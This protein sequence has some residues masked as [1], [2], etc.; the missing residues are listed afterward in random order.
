MNATPLAIVIPFDKHV[1]FH[2]IVAIALLFYTIAHTCGHYFSIRNLEKSPTSYGVSAIQIAWLS[3]PGL[4]GHL[5]VLVF[6]LILSSSLESVKKT[7]FEL[8]WYLHHLFTVF[9]ALNSIHGIFCFVIA[10]DGSCVSP[11]F[12]KCAIGP[13]ALYMAERLFREI[14]ARNKTILSKV[15][16]HPSMV[17]EMQVKKDG[18]SSKVGDYI[19]INCPDLSLFQ[20]HP[21]T[22]TSAPDD[23]FASVHVRV[24]GD[25]TTA[26]AHRL[27][28]V[29]K[30][31][32]LT[33]LKDYQIPRILIDGPYGTASGNIFSYEVTI[34]CGAGIGLTPFASIL[35]DIWYLSQYN[36]SCI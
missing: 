36:K 24:V 3:G 13:V 14:R 5:A 17:I 11:I 26:L 12:W 6:F 35:K 7:K 9:V 4:T 28:Y 1:A 20:W 2:K 32:Q 30:D 29:N 21:F 31:N 33:K 27:G 8:F 19:F 25:W 23:D 22:L 16:L 18:F 34:L 15:I 10:N